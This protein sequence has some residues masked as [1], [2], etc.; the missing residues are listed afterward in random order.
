MATQLSASLSATSP[1]ASHYS[2]GP[3]CCRRGPGLLGTAGRPARPPPRRSNHPFR[4]PSGPTRRCGHPHRRVAARRT[5]RRQCAPP[6][7][8]S[9]DATVRPS[10]RIRRDRDDTF[11]AQQQH[12]R[13]DGPLERTSPQDGD[14]RLAAFVVAA[15]VIGG[16]VGTE[17]A[18]RQRHAPGRVRPG[19]PDPRRRLRAARKRDR[20][21]PES[22]AHRRQPRV[23]GA[24]ADVERRVSAVDVVANVQTRTRRRTP[25]GFRP[26][27]TPRSSS[28]TSGATRTRP[29]TR[30][31]R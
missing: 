9:R 1:G 7:S 30:S 16:A 25:A 18:R 6:T 19:R 29:S 23:P 28:S 10:A 4:A 15:V 2:P 20:A 5:R 3:R 26:T 27:G 11:E 22:D 21:R 13:P 24:V 12:R 14:L 31:T 8:G 17:A